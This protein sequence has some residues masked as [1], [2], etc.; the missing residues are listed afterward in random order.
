VL[1]HLLGQTVEEVAEKVAVYR[2]AR[3]EAGYD[4]DTGIVS[5]ML[6]TFVGEDVD[7]VRE[8]V[9]EPMKDYLRSSANLVKSFAWAFPAFKRPKGEQASPADIDLGSISDEEMDAIMEFAFERYFETSGLFGT[10]DSCMA[11]IERVRAAGVDD[12][13]CL[14]DF[15]VPTPTVMEGLTHLA[16][17]RAACQPQPDAVPEPAAA[18][19]DHSIPALLDRYQVSHMQCTPSM[20]RMLVMEDRAR[21]ALGRLQNLMVGGEAFPV[22]LA[23]DLAKA[24]SG[25]ITNMYGPTETTIWSSTQR[26]VGDENV[27]AIGRPIANTQLYV[28]DA[29]L[30]PVPPGVPG[31]LYIGGDGVVRGYHERPELTAERFVRDPFRAGGARMYRTGDLARFRDDGVL[32]F[33]GRTDH[34]VKIRGYRIELGEIETLLNKHA[35]VREGVVVAREVA[36]GDQRLVAYLVAAGAA[37]EETLRSH[38]R[39]KLP[40]YMVPSHF[41]VLDRLPLTPNGKV[42]RKALPAPDKVVKAKRAEFVPPASDLEATIAEM[43]KET[44]GI[45]AVG[46]RDNFFDLGGHSLLVVRLHRLL[47]EAVPQQIPLTALYRFPTIASLAEH[48][49]GGDDSENLERSKDRA[50]KRKDMMQRRRRRPR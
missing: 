27:I 7:Q 30:Q 25:T 41:V 31:E 6:H 9:R 39:E 16:K 21:E 34:Q 36:P 23:H 20:A 29:R 44:L 28:L 11:M 45:D 1:T 22:A 43:W 14:I 33:L 12:V 13:A 10:P 48:L 5:L 4:P 38:L 35:S 50:Q 47:K 37:D 32:D 18:P 3:A 46:V 17:L 42:D 15:G 19:G 8:L 26:V 24:V 49:S 2:A 40:E